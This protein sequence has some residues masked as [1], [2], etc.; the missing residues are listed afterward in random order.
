MVAGA[1]PRLVAGIVQIAGDPGATRIERNL[2]AGPDQLDATIE[3]RRAA[4]AWH[5]SP[6]FAFDIGSAALRSYARLQF[7]PERSAEHAAY[8]DQAIDSLRGGLAGHPAQPYAW[9][10]L[11][12]ADLIRSGASERTG[13]W[14]R[15]SI[16]AGP[17]EPPLVVPR[18]A[19]ALLGWPALD[20]GTRA[21]VVGQIE[22][23]ASYRT[24]ELA[25][26]ALRLGAGDFVRTVLAARPELRQLFD[27]FFFEP[28]E[29]SPLFR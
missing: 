28:E 18:I 1:A 20:L 27:E 23:A 24:R 13:A 22:G 14:L 21:L 7:Q 2:P 29:G 26:M 16:L 6:Q 25:D 15:M 10:N 11:A 3:S 12:Y 19:L 9:M 5:A 4:S 8:L 17:E